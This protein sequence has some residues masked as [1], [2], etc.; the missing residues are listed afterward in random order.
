MPPGARRYHV[1]ELSR[2]ARGD[3][4]DARARALLEMLQGDPLTDGWRSAHV[5]DALDLCLACKGCKSDCPMQVDMA[6]YKAEFLSH[7]YARR[8]RPISAYAMGLIY[9]WARI[10]SFAPGFVN[11]FT[12]TQ[13]FA[14]FV[15]FLG[16]ISQRRE[17]PPFA[18]PSFR[19]WFLARGV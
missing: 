12:R 18:S 11:Y 14:A 2:D 5:R 4:L 3:A 19:H 6:T 13:P 7:Y 16:G 9:W 1:P 15:K 10:A 17:L 8:L